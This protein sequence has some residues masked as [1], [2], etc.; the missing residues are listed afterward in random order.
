[1]W[2][3]RMILSTEKK[4][5]KRL[6]SCI[7]NVGWQCNWSW[8]AFLTNVLN[9]TCKKR[10]LWVGV[11]GRVIFDA[12]DV[13]K[14]INFWSRKMNEFH[15]G[16]GSIFSFFFLVNFLR[17]CHKYSQILVNKIWDWRSPL[18]Q[19]ITGKYLNQERVLSAETFG[20]TCLN[21][22]ITICTWLPSSLMV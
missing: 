9:D 13:C 10:P 12:F 3:Q 19:Q 7:T 8:C 15:Q 2:F 18:E 11:Q 17:D 4:I 1:M 21:S 20:T 16:K 22:S 6:I 14:S 5:T